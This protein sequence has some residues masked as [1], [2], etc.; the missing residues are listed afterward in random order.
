[1]KKYAL[2]DSSNLPIIE[3]VFTGEQANDDNFPFYMQ[4]VKAVYKQQQKVVIIFDASNAVMPALKYQ[5]MQGDWL[6]ENEQLMKD[7][8]LGTAYIIP[9]LI[10]RNVLKAIFTLQKQPVEYLVCKSIDEAN[11][12]ISNQLMNN[13]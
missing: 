1:M 9:N 10:I 13:K 8:C 12:W 6:K 3:V 2:V 5:K 11:T 7:Y 4:E